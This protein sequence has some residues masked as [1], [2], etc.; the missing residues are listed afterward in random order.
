MLLLHVS[1]VTSS[2]TQGVIIEQFM[3]QRSI[4]EWNVIHFFVISLGPLAF[5]CGV[6]PLAVN[7][8]VAHSVL[9][10]YLLL[11]FIVL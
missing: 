9:S 10:F 4:L 5:V 2:R 1:A 8:H 6:K 11:Y 3:Q 7:Y